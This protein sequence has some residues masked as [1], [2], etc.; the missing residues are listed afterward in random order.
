[1]CTEKFMQI[2]MRRGCECL[3]VPLSKVILEQRTQGI[4]LV[5]HSWYKL[6]CGLVKGDSEILTRAAN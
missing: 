6:L 5:S 1:M 3:V 4:L 2:E